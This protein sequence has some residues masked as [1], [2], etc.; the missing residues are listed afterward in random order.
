LSLVHG[1]STSQLTTHFFHM[2]HT[3]RDLLVY[4]QCMQ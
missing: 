3:T 4:R 2:Q 1:T